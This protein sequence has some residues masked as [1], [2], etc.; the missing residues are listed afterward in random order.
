MARHEVAPRVTRVAS[1]SATLGARNTVVGAIE[2]FLNGIPD[3]EW[4]LTKDVGWF[5]TLYVLKVTGSPEDVDR[6]CQGLSNYFR[7]WENA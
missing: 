1:F 7:Q 3:L 2:N 4:W 5:E 6:A